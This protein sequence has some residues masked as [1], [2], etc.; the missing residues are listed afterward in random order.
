MGAMTIR[1][2]GEDEA[3]RLRRDAASRGV[4]V[5]SLLKLIVREALGLD[6][7]PRGQR[8][9]D[10]DSLAGTWSEEDEV[11]FEAAVQPFEQIEPG[12]WR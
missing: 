6:R 2:L 12:L 10:L 11:S 1:G 4:S 3:A 8:H 5:N 7:P 9:V